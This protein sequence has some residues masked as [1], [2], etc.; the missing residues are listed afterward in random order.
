[1]ACLKCGS[2]WV[3]ATGKN[4][5]SCPHCCKLARCRERKA[6]RWSDRLEPRDCVHCGRSF[7][8]PSIHQRTS[9]SCS[10]ACRKK[11][12][13]QWHGAW[14]KR[15]KTVGNVC[16][17][18]HG[19]PKPPCKR[20]GKE[21]QDRRLE[22]CCRDCYNADRKEG[23]VEWDMTGQQL[24]NLA[25]RRAQGLAMPS[26]VMY[27]AIQ[28]A[29]RR[30]LDGIVR[31]HRQLNAWRP[32]LHC[33]GP[34]KDHASERTMFCSIPCAAAYEHQITCRLCGTQ[35]VKRGVQGGRGMC[36]ACIRKAKSE[37]K[38]RE[39]RLKGNHRK[40][41]R[42]YGGFY[43]PA[44][45][46]AKVFERDEY[47]CH[48]CGKK[49]AP[50]KSHLDGNYPTVDHAPTPLSKGGDHDWHNVRCAC[51]DCNSR[52]GNSWTGQTPLK[53]RW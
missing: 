28:H 41:C 17:Q 5:A 20:C 2:D 42:L 27:A 40:R 12:K 48:V 32:C 33:G 4:C 34:L 10:P 39:K 11:H 50:H 47:R 9:Q 13:K 22:Y 8:P 53:L 7:I 14:R 6:G 35:C 25:K 21:V 24:G 23:L 37:H 3:T 45:T 46:S 15:H 36:T 52:K 49:T 16:V 43:N 31:L 19:Q 51:R 18:R 26:Q 44:V 38:R 29:M 1:M 30:H